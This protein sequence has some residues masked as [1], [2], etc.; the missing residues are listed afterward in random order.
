ME[1]GD[2]GAKTIRVRRCTKQAHAPKVVPQAADAAEEEEVI[3][4]DEEC[5]LPDSCC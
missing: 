2:E 1:I 4:D 3:E 5:D